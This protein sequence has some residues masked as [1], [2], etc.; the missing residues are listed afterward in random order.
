MQNLELG[1]IDLTAFVGLCKYH[2]EF[3][4]RMHLAV[5]FGSM[6]AQQAQEEIADAVEHPDQRE[7]NT[8]KNAM[9]R[10]IQ[11]AVLSAL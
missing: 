4:G 8:A 1:L 7:N 2:I 11:S 3:F 9:G 10:L 6:K 5:A